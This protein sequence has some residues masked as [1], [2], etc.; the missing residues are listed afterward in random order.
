MKSSKTYLLLFLLIILIIIK[1]QPFEKTKELKEGGVV[2]I[3]ISD[4]PK[5]YTLRMEDGVYHLSLKYLVLYD[6]TS[7]KL[8][9]ELEDGFNRRLQLFDETMNSNSQGLMNFDSTLEFIDGKEIGITN[10]IYDENI[11]TKINLLYD[12]YG[13]ENDVIVFVPIYNDNTKWCTDGLSQGFNYKGKIFF[14][15]EAYFNPNN[16][17]ENQGAIGLMTHK[18]LHGVGFNHQDQMYKQ[19]TLL[20]WYSGLPETNMFLHGNF[21]EFNQLYFDEYTIKVLGLKERSE[22]E[23]SCL[24]TEE[25]IC[26]SKNSYF[27]QDS[28]GP[29]CQDIDK[30]NILDSD[31]QYVLS[32]P[33][34]GNDSDHDGI[35]DQLDLCNWNEFKVF[36]DDELIQAPLRIKAG[37]EDAI[38]S[39]ESDNSIQSISLTPF[40]MVGGLIVFD[41]QKKI[42]SAGSKVT[43]SKS[44]VFWRIEVL[45]EYQNKSYIRPFFITFSNFDADFVYEREW[46][47]FNRFGCDMPKTVKLNNL[48][49]YDRNVNGLPD[50]EL[51][52]WAKNINQTYDW[53]D[54]GVID[55][56]DT[57]PTVQ[58]FCN[59]QHVKGVK[60]S[61]EDGFCD[62][63]KFRF[64]ITNQIKDYELLMVVDINE[65]TDFCPFTSGTKNGCSSDHEN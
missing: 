48:Q 2:S 6:R 64:D 56:E 47:Y 28:W 63:G 57:L 43:I 65:K 37:Y 54:D 60:D 59:N 14:C 23:K 40:D 18:F 29:F 32:S 27:C 10:L 35:V 3:D 15:M 4:G 9:P 22:F 17:I 52:E 51:F 62:P 7:K 53:D 19:Y 55:T 46:Y 13:K 31:D 16:P 8:I 49:T 44:N 61:D 34:R 21:R 1:I 24:D 38:L 42:T 45:Y 39:F 12:L 33:I 26:K 20:D 41:E 30:D 11:F 50:K 36:F 58:G 5:E 25:F